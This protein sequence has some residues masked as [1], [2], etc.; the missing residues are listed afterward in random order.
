MD[1]RATMR[2]YRRALSTRFGGR[3]AANIDHPVAGRGLFLMRKVRFLYC[4]AT[5]RGLEGC[6]LIDGGRN[7]GP[8]MR[9][10]LRARCAPV[11]AINRAPL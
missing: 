4:G 3:P 8:P 9:T 6:V 10:L 7:A 1:C 2:V 5:E 11:A